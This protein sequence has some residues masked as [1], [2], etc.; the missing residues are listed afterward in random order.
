[1]SYNILEAPKHRSCLGSGH[2]NLYELG[3]A[4]SVAGVFEEVSNGDSAIAQGLRCGSAL[5][6]D[7]TVVMDKNFVSCE[8]GSGRFGCTIESEATAAG[9]RRDPF[10]VCRNP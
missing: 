9:T 10:P 6:D 1:M 5:P 2:I 3:V 7:V 4:E 8:G